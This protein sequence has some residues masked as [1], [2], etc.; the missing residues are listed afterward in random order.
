MAKWR[1]PILGLRMRVCLVNALRKAY[2]GFSPTGGIQL[3]HCIRH[4][5]LPFK[6]YFDISQAARLRHF[7]LQ[8]LHGYCIDRFTEGFLHFELTSR[9]GP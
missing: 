2:V 3:V 9:F 6:D 4:N 5:S 1:P 7:G 8:V